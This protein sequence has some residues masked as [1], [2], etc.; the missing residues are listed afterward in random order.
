MTDGMGNPKQQSQGTIITKVE[1]DPILSK[2][3]M[4]EQVLNS[5]HPES[6][7]YMNGLQYEDCNLLGLDNLL[8]VNDAFD[9][10]KF[11]QSLDESQYSGSQQMGESEENF[12]LETCNR[13]DITL[14]D[15]NV[16]LGKDKQ[17]SLVRDNLSIKES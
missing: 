12:A 2:K 1:Q 9:C 15:I 13:Q 5:R 4:R 11:E 16:P 17:N 6:D 14:K 3:L 10:Y 8:Q 7:Q